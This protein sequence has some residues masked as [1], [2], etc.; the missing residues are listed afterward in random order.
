MRSALLC[1]ALLLA[2]SAAPAASFVVVHAPVPILRRLLRPLQCRG[3]ATLVV[4][5]CVSGAEPRR[6]RPSLGVARRQAFGIAA[7]GVLGVVL[8]PAASHADS[9]VERMRARRKAQGLGEA[10]SAPEPR[11]GLGEAPAAPEPRAG[12]DDGKG[13]VVRQVGDE[14]AATPPD[15]VQA[16]RRRKI[17]EMAS[18]GVDELGDTLEKAKE[19]GAGVAAGAGTAFSVLKSVSQDAASLAVKAIDVTGKALDV[20]VPATKKAIEVATPIVVDVTKKAVDVATPMIERGLEV[21][22]DAATKASPVVRQ[23]AQD[24]LLN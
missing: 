14:D 13:A 7:V 4:S 20:A 8:R 24:A 11:K 3:G 1:A 10:P 6:Q 2:V 18:Q 12:Q 21:A 22:Q 19:V 5:M 16:E 23:V 9:A 17:A 15:D